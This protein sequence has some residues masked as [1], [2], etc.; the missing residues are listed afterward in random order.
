MSDEIKCLVNEL[1]AEHQKGVEANELK[2][3]SI[4]EKLD[5]LESGLQEKFLSA[6]QAK[7]LEDQLANLEDVVARASNVKKSDSSKDAPEYKSLKTFMQ[8][9]DRTFGEMEAKTLRVDTAA[10]GGVLV[11]EDMER[12]IVKNITEI[13]PVRAVARVRTTSSASVKFPVR[14]SLLNAQWEGE[15]EDSTSSTSTYGMV[16][17]S[18]DRLSVCVP[19]SRELL[20]DSV[21]DMEADILSDYQ[22]SRMQKEGQAFVI[23]DGNKKPMG[24]MV[25]PTVAS[26]DISAGSATSQDVADAILLLTGDLKTGYNPIFGFNRRTLAFI[27]TLKDSQGRYI[28]QPALNGEVAPTI[29]GYTY[30]LMEDVPDLV[31]SSGDLIVDANGAIAFADFR[32]AYYIVDKPEIVV[33]RDEFTAKN[34]NVIEFQFHARTSGKVVKPEAITKLVV[35]A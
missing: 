4:N 1:Q 8:K 12:S 13:S 14:N 28:Y 6:E 27:R 2:I 32:E 9:G 24:F 21:F 20:S 10:E 34:R 7:G 19:I 15:L 26:R 18:P 31:D 33:I 17:I 11:P 29:A 35:G 23:G 30:A 25:D 3:K 22:E 16:E 5:L